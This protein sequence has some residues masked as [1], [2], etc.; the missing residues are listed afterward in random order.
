MGRVEA[1]LDRW[2]GAEGSANDVCVW[3]AE[4]KSCAHVLSDRATCNTGQ[5]DVLYGKNDCSK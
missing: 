2:Q 3:C 4:V 5:H 1:L